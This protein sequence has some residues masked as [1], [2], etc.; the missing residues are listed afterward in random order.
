MDCVPTHSHRCAV[1]PD[2]L[3]SAG[4]G[5]ASGGEAPARPIDGGD[6]RVPRTRPIREGWR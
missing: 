1:V 4:A 3:D 6:E 2:P 5:V